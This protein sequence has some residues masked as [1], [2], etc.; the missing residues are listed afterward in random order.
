LSITI[1]DIRDN[2]SSFITNNQPVYTLGNESEN[3]SKPGGWLL[4]GYIC[5]ENSKAAKKSQT[6]RSEGRV[7]QAVQNPKSPRQQ[8]IHKIEKYNQLRNKHCKTGK[9]Q[10]YRFGDSGSR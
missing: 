4:W 9:A 6:K 7:S 3:T 5:V 1:S 2:Q 8:I 10:A